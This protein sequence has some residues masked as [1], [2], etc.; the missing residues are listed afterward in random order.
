MA[1][2]ANHYERAFEAYLRWL[3][4]S[5]IPVLESR[6]VAAEFQTLKSLDFVVNRPPMGQLLIDVKGRRAPRGKASLENWTTEDDVDSLARWQEEFGN[7]ALPLFV[8]VYQLASEAARADFHD[9][10]SHEDRHYGCLSIA[11]DD[12]RVHIRQRSPRWRTV[13]IPAAEFQRLARPFSDWLKP[14]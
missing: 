5:W 2:R 4:V 14:P 9:S 6:R 7:Q 11:L 8:F 1:D 12:Y 13:S 10:F 3:R